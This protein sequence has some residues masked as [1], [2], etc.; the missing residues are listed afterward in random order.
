VIEDKARTEQLMLENHIDTSKKYGKVMQWFR[1]RSTLAKGAIAGATSM[2]FG[3]LGAVANFA[4]QHRLGS[5][6]IAS[7]QESIQQ[8]NAADDQLLIDAV[9]GME[10]YSPEE[11]IVRAAQ[12]Y[13]GRVLR[14]RELIDRDTF[15]VAMGNL[16][17]LVVG[18]TVSIAY[19][20]A[21]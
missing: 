14:D 7:N 19:D 8:L 11:T 1:N 4:V 5:R 10:S 21:N 2:V 9:S 6:Y 3:G 18:A 17:G 20:A 16:A 13:D 15:P 12:A